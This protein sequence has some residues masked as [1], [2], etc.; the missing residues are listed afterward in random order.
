MRLYTSCYTEYV[1]PGTHG[2][3]TG[4]SVFDFD[5][6]LGRVQLLFEKEGCNLSYMAFNKEHGLLYAHEEKEV[7]RSPL[8][9][10]YRINAA[11]LEKVGTIRIP[12]GLPCHI[13]YLPKENRIVVACYETG[14]IH[15]YEVDE[16]GIPSRLL[17]SIQHE[18]SS[19]HPYRQRGPHAHMACYHKEKVYV[20]DLG[21]DKVMVYRFQNGLLEL[22]YEIQLPSGG[23]PRHLTFHKGGQFAFV[24]NE[25]SGQVSVLKKVGEQFGV[26][27]NVLAIPPSYEGEAAA[28]TL[29]TTG[30]YLLV[31][32]RS[33]N[34]I[35]S[36]YFDLETECLKLLFHTDSG[37][38]SPRDF[39]LSTG[40]E[41]L[42]VANQGSHSLM[43]FRHQD[44]TLS[45]VYQVESK[46]VCCVKIFPYK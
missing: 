37:G 17:Q 20:P 14:S 32:L 2:E 13:S 7:G 33:T 31:G 43:V 11:R 38:Q 8:L 1:S 35:A 9:D 22:D 46:S 39:I 25:L 16:T 29:L 45:P 15:L 41:W 4:I 26:I 27:Q 23:G 18:G 21:L 19:T 24:A 5:P 30:N 36:M 34:S 3:G 28:S 10:T 44:G 40:G 42:I 6:A 12:G